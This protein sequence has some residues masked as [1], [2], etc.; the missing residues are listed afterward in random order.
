MTICAPSAGTTSSSIVNP[1]SRSR[2]RAARRAA[3]PRASPTKSSLSS[4]GS[5]CMLAVI[6]F[7]SE[8]VSCPT[9]TWPFSSRRIRCGSSPNGRAPASR[10]GPTGTRRPGSGSGARIQARRRSRC[11]RREAR[12]TR[13]LD[14]LRVQVA[15]LVLADVL[16][17]LDRAS[18]SASRARGPAEVQAQRAP[19]S[20]SRSR[21]RSPRPRSTTRT[22]RSPTRAGRGR[23]DVVEV[24]GEPSDGAVVHD[25][26]A[27]VV[28]T[29]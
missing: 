13:D 15:E 21:R 24:V 18:A 25:P 28:R 23:R 19:R 17:V 27:S 14:V 3:R 1:T 26:A 5:Q 22:R 4:F 10:A 7:D 16:R 20:R 29:P 8:S 9:I 11:G 2:S 12:D 6:R